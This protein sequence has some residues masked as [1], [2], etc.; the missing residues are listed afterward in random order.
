MTSVVHPAEDTADNV[1]TIGRLQEVIS[2]LSEDT[3]LHIAWKIT[4]TSTH[5]SVPRRSPRRGWRRG[6]AA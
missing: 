3:P 1:I 4:A 2:G 6:R 5:C